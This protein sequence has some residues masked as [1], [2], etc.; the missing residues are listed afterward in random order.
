MYV[1]IVPGEPPQNVQC[2]PLTAESLRMSWNPPP[3]QSHHGTI[4]GYKIQ[5]KKVNPKTGKILKE[6][7]YFLTPDV[8]LLILL[9]FHLLCLRID[10]IKHLLNTSNFLK[11]FRFHLF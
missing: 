11:Y 10:N 3:I 2:S 8:Y 4:L 1:F 6:N 9:F 5:Y 7:N